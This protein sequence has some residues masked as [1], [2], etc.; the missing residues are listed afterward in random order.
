[1]TAKP[2]DVKFNE[3]ERALRKS[4]EKL[5]GAAIVCVRQA[6]SDLIRAC[7]VFDDPD[8]S[9]LKAWLTENLRGEGNFQNIMESCHSFATP[10]RATLNHRDPAPADLL[11][12]AAMDLEDACQ[13]LMA[14]GFADLPSVGPATVR[15]RIHSGKIL[16]VLHA[17]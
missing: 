5:L 12:I 1:M 9:S 15:S 2:C 7:G 6:T 14:D 16:Q 3:A 8:A 17:R 10:R 4:A 13:C 11:V